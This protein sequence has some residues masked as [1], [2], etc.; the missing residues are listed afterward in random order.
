M[1]EEKVV[2][3]VEYVFFDDML[4][5]FFKSGFIRNYME[6]VMV[7]LFQNLYLIVEEKW[8]YVVWYK[9]YF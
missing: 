7:G 5:D 2:L 4:E 1:D 8:E 3:F 6:Q 9:N